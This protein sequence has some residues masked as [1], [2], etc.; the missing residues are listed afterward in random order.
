MGLWRAEIDCGVYL[1]ESSFVVELVGPSVFVLHVA[2]I[3]PCN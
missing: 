3:D 2:A 1:H